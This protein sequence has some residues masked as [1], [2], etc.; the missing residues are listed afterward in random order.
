MRVIDVEGLVL[1]R[2]ASLIAKTLLE[3]GRDSE[4]E[5]AVV[6]AERAIITGD[7]K[8][9]LA[10]YLVRRRL[11]HPRKGPFFPRMPDQILKRTIRGMLPYQKPRGRKAFRSMKVYIG[12]PPAF[13]GMDRESLDQARKPLPPKYMTVGDLADH[14]GANYKR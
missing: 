13:E 6:N 14:L 2:A 11:N 9:I 1:G 3:E 4:E 12:V 10:E 8:S 5:F 7:P